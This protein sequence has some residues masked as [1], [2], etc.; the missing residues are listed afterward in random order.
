[1]LKE[2]LQLHL[3][4]TICHD[5]HMLWYARFLIQN[6]NDHFSNLETN[7][8]YPL[9][10]TS[11]NT[12]L[13]NLD[14]PPTLGRVALL[15]L[16][17]WNIKRYNRSKHIETHGM[18]TNSQRAPLSLDQPIGRNGTEETKNKNNGNGGNI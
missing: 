11:I 10:S 13:T 8:R 14:Q 3:A 18:G 12:N 2:I 7:I 6:Q 16:V 4:A 5:D 9:I 1:M 15:A 17:E